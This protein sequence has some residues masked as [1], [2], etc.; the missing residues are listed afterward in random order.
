[1][2]LS[3]RLIHIIKEA[4]ACSFND[5]EIY[6]FGSRVDDNKKGGDIN[7]AI[8][9]SAY[10]NLFKQQKI[11]FKTFLFRHGYDL[12]IDLVQFNNSIDTVLL[13]EIKLSGIKI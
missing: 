12:K 5:A 3:N 9:T 11:K 4:S 13:N 6:L 2:R 8:K 1:M 7:L 10:K